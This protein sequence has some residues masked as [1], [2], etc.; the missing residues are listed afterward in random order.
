M[1]G[2]ALSTRKKRKGID[3]SDDALLTPKKARIRCALF[4]VC[5]EYS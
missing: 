5:G 4:H 3:D 2:L 1:D